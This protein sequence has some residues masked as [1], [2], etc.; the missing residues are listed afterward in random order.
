M[1][2]VALLNCIPVVADAAPGSYNVGPEEVAEVISPLT[3][4]IV[5][6]HLGGE[7]VDIEGILTLAAEKNI[8]IVEDVAQSPGATVNGQLVGTFGRV[9]SFSTM[10]GKHYCTGGQ[11]GM[12][13]TKDEALYARIRHASDRGKPFGLPNSNGNC[14][15]S[16]NFNMGEIGAAIG[17]VQLA[18][19]P[20][21]VASR[22]KLVGLLSQAFA[23][24]ECLVI[25]PQVT[26]AEASYWFW[27]IEVNT[28][29]LTCD[30]DTFCA[31]VAAEGISLNPCY[32]AM[33]HTQDWF[34]KRQVFGQSGLPWTSPLY[35]GDPDRT[36]PC[37]N[38]IDA[39][40]RQFNL[41]VCETWGEAEVADLFAAFAKVEAA[42]LK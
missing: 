6:A 7:P 4:A 37:P 13:F 34:V 32:P 27:R 3:S 17:R 23:E 16:L 18:R 5:I 1:M 42:Y 41:T 39:T 14:L 35:K 36:F 12:V 26:G 21:I 33:P 8:P 9:S 31:A 10:F 29:R 24:L 22:R 38:A 40:S 25:P 15:A 19:L 11:G 20:G 2:P 28:D 30:K